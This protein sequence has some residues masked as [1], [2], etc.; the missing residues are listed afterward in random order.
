MD[1]TGLSKSEVGRW[2]G[3]ADQGF[4]PPLVVAMLERDCQFAPVT[5][6]MAEAS[7]R[8]LTDPEQERAAEVSILSAHAE[9]MRH[10]SEVSSALA[11]AIADGVVTPSEAA[12][13]DRKVASHE[14]ATS[15]LRASLAVLKARGGHALKVVG[16]D[17]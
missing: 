9:M 1:K 10:G 17:E 12:I 5:S 6:V 16:G 2:F 8:R 4:M 13:V 3:G 11:A 14:R 15:E 7:G